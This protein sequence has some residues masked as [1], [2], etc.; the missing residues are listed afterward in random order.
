MILWL[1]PFTGLSGD[2]LLG[3]LLDLGA[4]LAGIRAAVDTT[5][6]TGWELGA[7]T[8]RS[9]GLL[10]TRALVEVADDVTQRRAAELL[11]IV[12]RAR[13][14]PVAALAVRALRAI[15]RVEARLHGRDEDD[16]VLHELGGLDTVVDTVG[17][18][19]GLHLLGVTAVH[20]APLPL[21][22]SG[23]STRHG[24]LPAPAPATL[25]LLA[26]AGAQVCGTDLDG[27]T[28]TPTGAALL[29]AA[30]ARYGPSPPM[31]L[32]AVGYGAGARSFG[33]RANVVQAT[34]GDPVT[35]GSPQVLIESNVDDVTGE[36]LGHLIGQ[37]IAA[38]AADAWVSPI[39]M[40]KN[41]PAH[42]VHVL[43]PRERA[44]E[45]ERLLLAE[46]GSLGLR[47]TVVDKLALPRSVTT[48]E[49]DGQPVTVKRGPW[50]AKAEH[51]DVVAAA[52]A[53]GLPARVVARRAL[54]ALPD[55]PGPG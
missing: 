40:K 29:A 32:R 31:T 55:R 42:T 16:V 22:T 43:A 13:P 17:V 4:P 46:T 5:G 28:V 8:L 39:T 23:V 44:A 48:V 12:G 20:C 45:L 24:R 7:G 30:G 54:D 37:A 51:D 11:D 9:S 38:G 2:M 52:A 53:L 18:A 25:A 41:R 33:A 49:V 1:H 50:G 36:V 15:T 10:A 3:A 34:L 6:I 47:R 14:A 21:G 26:E 27:E 19:A 35:A